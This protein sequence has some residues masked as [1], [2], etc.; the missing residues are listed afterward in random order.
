MDTTTIRVSEPREMLA[1][2]PHQLGFRPHE[3]AVA[4]SLR[5]PRGRIGLVAR[6]DLADLGDVV[7]GPQVARG[8][9]AH[10]GA[11]GA[12]R[13]VLVLYTAQDPRGPDSPPVA[14]A[15]AEH[16]REAAAAGLS[17]V[18]VWVVTADGYLAL[19]CDDAGC[20]PPG[21]R[22]LR[23][24]ESTAVGAQLVLAGSAVADCRADVARIPAAGGDARR[25]VARV[26]ARWRGR[27]ERA[28]ADG[29]AALTA[30]RLAS[31]AAWRDEVAV[32]LAGAP[33]VGAP[34]LGRLDV[35]LADTRVRD[36]VLVSM[37]PGPPD[38]PE[39]SLREAP[40]ATDALVA[41]AVAGIVDQRR[42][43]VP[44]PALTA[45]HVSVLERVVGH[46][47]RGA[48]APACTLLALLAWWQA[49][50][51]RAGLLLERALEEDPDHRLARILDRTLAVA[52]PP[53]WVRRAG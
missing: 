36:A 38:L 4:V 52:M 2:L 13:A 29:P 47:R 25:S 28:L 26:A 20:C 12:G 14:R 10:L 9:V 15:A 30:W 11:D 5:P 6:V 37:V 51:A 31:L 45:A 21:G 34:A 43:V 23:D 53:G 19:D 18:A 24:L 22:A 8:L 3:S 35:A 7:H 46:G 33:S 42:G 41:E 17:D 27:R 32:V 1:Y 50:G 16:F 40:G 39:R 49:D 48:Q 44:P